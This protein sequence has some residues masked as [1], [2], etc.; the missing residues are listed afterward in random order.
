[1]RTGILP[2]SE[3]AKRLSQKESEVDRLRRQ[4]EARLGK[5]KDRKQKL[6][7]ELRAVVGQIQAASPTGSVPPASLSDSEET[8]AKEPVAPV[9]RRIKLKGFL[10]A[11]IKEAGKPLTVKELAEEV[12]RRKFP[13]KSNDIPRLIQTRVYDM[14][15]KGVLAHAS[16][17]PGYVVSSLNGQPGT[18]SKLARV[19][20]GPGRKAKVAK[21]PVRAGLG[22]QPPLREVLTTILEQSKEPLGGPE[23]AKKALATGYKSAS[24]S[25]QG[26]VYVSLAQMKNV[27]H[28]RG[29][30]YRLKKR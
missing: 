23:L 9:A 8:A 22:S 30:G 6:E 15:K 7:S 29:Q 26:V 2:L 3:L 19:K 13:T 12:R 11:L 10:I 20:R 27:E 1:M 18:S 14:A 4:Y 28:I 25:F 21:A 17:Q 16:G 5:L 24:K